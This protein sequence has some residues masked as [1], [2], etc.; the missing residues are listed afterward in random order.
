MPYIKPFM[1]DTLTPTSDARATDPGELNYQFTR[2]AL[3]YFGRVSE[4]RGGYQAIND[5]LGALEG[6]KLEFY[7]R[8]AAPY[9]DS[10]IVA[11]GDVYEGR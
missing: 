9:E 1:R 7:R 6:A 3:D 8:I 11:N 10:K 5:V 4:L 2:L